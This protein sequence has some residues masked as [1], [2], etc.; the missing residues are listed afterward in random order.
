MDQNGMGERIA[1]VSGGSSGIG[2]AFVAD[3]RGRGYTVVTCARDPAKLGQLQ[4]EYPGVECHAVDVSDAAAMRDFARKVLVAH[5][6]IDLLVSNAG[7]L[8][9]VDFTSEAL[10]NQDLTADIRSN[11]DGA[12]HLVGGFV[13]GL[14][15]S[16][17]ASIII[18]S[19]GYALAPAT[20]APIYSAS[21]AALHSLSKSLRRQLA[22][23]NITVTEVAPPAVDTPSTAHRKVPKMAARD[24]VAEALAAASRGVKEVYPGGAR[25]LPLLLRIA[26]SWME[27]RVARR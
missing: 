15:R 7:G 2:K 3:L 23:L 21:K 11:L 13:P 5:P 9:Q 12:I 27:E 18:I 17:K 26:P 1:V 22:P 8:R 25:W 6:A 14:R 16:A 10:Q 24:V 4:T 19:S 20:R